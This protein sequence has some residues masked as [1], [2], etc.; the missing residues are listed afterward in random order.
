[1]CCYSLVML[2]VVSVAGADGGPKHGAVQVAHD[3]ADGIPDGTTDELAIECADG[4]PKYEPDGGAECRACDHLADQPGRHVRAHDGPDD[5]CTD[6]GAN[7]TSYDVAV[8]VAK[9]GSVCGPDEQPDGG[10]DTGP[11]E[12][13]EQG[14]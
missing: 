4:G 12:Q 9:R 8:G 1:M 13:P 3:A 6:G 5:G 2:V 10:A 11:D 14:K 7:D